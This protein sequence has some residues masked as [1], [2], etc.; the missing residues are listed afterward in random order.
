VTLAANYDDVVD[1]LLAAGL[2]GRGVDDGLRIGAMVRTKVD[3]DREKRGWYLL[4]ELRTDSGDTLIVGSFGVWRGTDNGATKVEL[5]KREI[6]A[7]QRDALRARLAE[8]RKRA[9]QAR[10]A[11]AERAARRAQGLW[12]KLA[13]SGDSAYLERKGVGAY[14]LR[15]SPK[16]GAAVVPVCDAGGRIHGLQILRPSGS[17]RQPAKQFWPTGMV[18]RG[19]F[20]LFGGS[21]VMMVLVAEGYATGATLHA[22]TG[23]PVAVAF[24]AGNLA[25]VC[26]ALRK[27]YRGAKILICA[28]DDSFSEGNPGITA[29]STAAVACD[30][31][32]V[33]PTWSPDTQAQ[34]EARAAKGDKLTD[35]NDL[36]A[37]EGL[38]AVRAVIEGKLTAL[39]WRQAPAAAPSP[40]TEGEGSRRD[41]RPID[42]L[43][44]LIKRYALVY[45]AKGLVFD[46]A[47]HQL[48]AL[49]DMRDACRRRELHRA[50]QEHPDRAIVRLEEVGFDPGGE[51]PNI[52]CNLWSGWPTTPKA[53]RCDKLLDLL[54]HMTEREP[55]RKALFDW[56]LR[57]LAY[58][59]QHPGA[60]MKT[61]LVV[62]G[63]QGTGKNLFFEAVMAIY[64]RYGRVIDQ[65]AIEDKFN[66]WASRKLFLIADEVVARSDLYHVKNKLKAFITGDWIRINAKN[67]AAY[68]ERNHVNLVFLSNEAQ[69]V[70]IEEDDRRH[71]VL[72]TPGKLAG[73]FYR[74]VLDELRDGGVAALHEHLLRVDLADFNPGTLP[75]YTDA[76]RELADLSLDSPSKFFYDLES[77]QVGAV[78]LAPC[79]SQ[80]LYDLYRAYCARAGNRHARTREQFINAWDRKHGVRVARKRYVD[81]FNNVLGPTAF[82]MA[83]RATPPDG[84]T[85]QSW[86]GQCAEAFRTAAKDYREVAYAA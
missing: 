78:K 65:T 18:K 86:L 28:D 36:A 35:F 47:E 69:P 52:R 9:D 44:E 84:M 21:P 14:G 82:M 30:G 15:F 26:Q 43:D 41:L 5:R 81:S 12:S 3:G 68:D 58:P 53:G 73:D 50:W 42:D 45:A 67:L 64:G 54:W 70:V 77:G 4:H 39:K 61:T 8:D 57:W 29:A 2:R 23:Y 74:G 62:H 66:D 79:P 7:E 6:S 10:A 33:A 55:E 51:D 40:T 72:W 85:E 60:K 1:Q 76:K 38:A 71:A 17:D 46:F 48:V 16:S 27:R 32:W 19:H 22:A 56:I 75:P 20:H 59:I 11:E 24:D 34:R 31:A 37:L 80:D 25:P 83:G 49:S 63:P 13:P